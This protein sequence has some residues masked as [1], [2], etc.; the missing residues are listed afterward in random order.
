VTLK[1]RFGNV[2]TGYVGTVH[3]S[4]SDLLA[5]LPADYTFKGTDAGTRVFS[6]TLAT[7]LAQRLSVNDTANASLGTSSM[8]TVTLAVPGL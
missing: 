8:I 3:F 1:D 6:V 7:P 5:T 4:S 2:A